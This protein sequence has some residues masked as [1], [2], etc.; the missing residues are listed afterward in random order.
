MDIEL[1]NIA[2][3]K[4]I[5]FLYELLKERPDNINISHKEIPSY[6]QHKKYVS[7]KPYDVWFI[8]WKNSIRV[9]SIY[10]TKLG[11]IG[12]FVKKEYQR[13]GIAK[14]TIPM[15]YGYGVGNNIANVNPLNIKSI[16]LFKQLGFEH[17]QN[18]YKLR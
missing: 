8:I 4:D 2:D 16:C 7:S 9:G 13:Q 3:E 14:N 12:I 11:E 18:T 1:K 10:K 15:I 5:V 17:I 6:E